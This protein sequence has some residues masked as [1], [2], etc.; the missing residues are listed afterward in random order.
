MT[1]DTSNPYSIRHHQLLLNLID[2][3]PETGM[4]LGLKYILIQKITHR[5]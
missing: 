5:E 3:A 2:H 4:I 1:Q